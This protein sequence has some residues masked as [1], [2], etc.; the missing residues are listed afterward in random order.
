MTGPDGKDYTK[1]ELIGL[2]AI[3]TGASVDRALVA[4]AANAN[5]F[6]AAERWLL[7]RPPITTP[8]NLDGPEDLFD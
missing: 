1:A 7:A 3:R 4:L 5:D 2:L 6:D 8:Q